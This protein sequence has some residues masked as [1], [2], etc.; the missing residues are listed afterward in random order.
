MKFE[1]E[2]VHGTLIKRYKRFLADILLDNGE[3]VIAHCTNTGS[4]ASCLE[5][6]AEVYISPAANPG[7]KTKYT[8]EMIKINGSWVGI[9]TGNPNK[10]VYEEL[11][12]GAIPDLGGY[13][14]VQREVKYGDSRFDVFA[15][16]SHEKCFVEV[17]NVTYKEGC[18]ALFPD[19]VTS[20]G[21][22]HLHALKRVKEEGMRA[23]MAY[24]VQRTDVSVFAPA[25]LI[26]PE[27]SK[28]LKEVYSLGVEIFPLQAQVSPDEIKIHKILP[29]QL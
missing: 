29:F 10:L 28:T 6:G 25:K 14:L 1:K 17:K 18:F 16:N 26:D 12:A 9:N 24:V 13:D 7:R 20:R 21:L 4:M 2:L 3:T 22:K 15:E 11:K 23:V 5:D 19:A 27:Y 8:W